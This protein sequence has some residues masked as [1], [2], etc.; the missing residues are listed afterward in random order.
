MH[1]ASTP[2]DAT[3]LK[4]GSLTV[5]MTKTVASSDQSPRSSAI[6]AQAA[7]MAPSGA[8]P[9]LTNRQMAISSLRAIAMMAIRRVRP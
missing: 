5:P 6:K 2:A 3:Y 7:T 4:R 1:E 8:I 9:K